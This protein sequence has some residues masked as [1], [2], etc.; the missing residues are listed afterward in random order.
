MSR[1]FLGVALVAACAIPVAAPPAASAKTAPPAVTV[2]TR[3]LY[4]GADLIPLATQPNAAAFEQAAAQRLQTVQGND[5]AMRA[6]GIAAEIAAKKPDLVG[7]QEAA[8]WYRS[9]DGVKDGGATQSTQLIYDSVAELQK[10]LAARYAPYTLVRKRPWFDFEAPTSLGFDVRLVQQDAILVRKG[11]RVRISRSFD[12]GYAK[13]FDV[14]T[15]AG[16]ARSRRGWVG[17]DAKV[18]NRSFRFVTTH[19]EAYSPDIANT[20]MKQLLARTLASKKRQTILV[21]DFNSDPKTAGSDRGASRTP[22]AYGTALDAGFF[23]LLPRRETCCEPEDLHKTGKLDQWIDHI[24]VRPKLRVVRSSI[25]GNRTS[26]RVG[27][28]WPSDHAGIAATLRL[29]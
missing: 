8:V 28:L 22:S 6:K 1:R 9:P 4:L 10:Q 21:G 26:D 19:L 11:S 16:L 24:I 2:M 5:F 23:N 29:R 7:L 15:F 18:G 13:T 12:G 25:V 3:N 27:G 17:A 14:T 20:Q